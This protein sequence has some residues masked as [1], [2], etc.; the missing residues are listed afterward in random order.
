MFDLFFLL[1][2]DHVTIFICW[3][4]ESLSNA[5]VAGCILGQDIPNHPL[6]N[7]GLE[8]GHDDGDGVIA[9][10]GLLHQA[11]DELTDARHDDLVAVDHSVL[12]NQGGICHGLA[13]GEKLEPRQFHLY[14]SKIHFIFFRVHNLVPEC[15]AKAR[16]MWIEHIYSK[17]DRKS[18]NSYC[19]K[20]IVLPYLCTTRET[21]FSLPA[22]PF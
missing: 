9:G 18:R 20:Y 17:C 10:D 12:T 1:S 22:L 21:V 13:L 19:Q 16:Q 8:V 5:G 4:F 14:Y 11:S 6:H 2:F 3:Y 7:D 15:K